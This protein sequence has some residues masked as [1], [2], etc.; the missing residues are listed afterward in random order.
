M[1]VV[2]LSLLAAVLAAGD[3]PAADNPVLVEL[4]DKGVPMSD[5]SSVKLP[6]PTMGD[7]LDDDGQR[8]ALDKIADANHPISELARK[9]IVAPFVLT[10]RSIKTPAGQSPA[11]AVDAWFI[12]Y[13]D[14]DTI[15]SREFLD[16][17]A[18]RSE[19]R[20]ADGQLTQSGLLE[21]AALA[22]RKIE[23]RAKEGQE[24][25]YFHATLS[26]FD[27][28]E[29]SGTRYALLTRKP[30]SFLAAATIDPRFNDDEE[31]PNYWRSMVR[32]L[33]NPQKVTFGPRHVY[34]SAG[35][36][37]KVT[38][39]SNPAGAI[40]LEYHLVFE[41]PQGWF[42]GANLLRS[43]LPLLMQEEVRNFRRK[44]VNASRGK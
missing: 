22:K 1:K 9:S 16:G 41:E 13:G 39:L 24:E 4:L 12:A 15:Q 23:A 37:G 7:G 38:R 31:Y 5:G 40:F 28:V 21:E 42:K 29:I 27:K 3:A 26:L 36:Y 32:D 17:L 35:F 2:L 10:I 33:D 25:R 18:K 8:A 34:T 20:S 30:D 19:Q 6:P 14:W 44:L 43:K 11:R